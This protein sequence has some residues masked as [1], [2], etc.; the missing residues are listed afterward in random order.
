MRIHRLSRHSLSPLLAPQFC[1]QKPA[2]ARFPRDDTSAASLVIVFDHAV[3][4][5]RSEVPKNP[6]RYSQPQLRLKFFI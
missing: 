6:V 5:A 2:A 4:S 3:R 1:F